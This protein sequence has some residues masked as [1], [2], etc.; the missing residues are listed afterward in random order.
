[1]TKKIF[2]DK[3]IEQWERDLFEN[4]PPPI[5]EI[6][7]PDFS[8]PKTFRASAATTGIVIST[9]NRDGNTTNLFLNPV[10]AK[11]LIHTIAMQGQ[12]AGWLNEKL[13]IISPD[14]LLNS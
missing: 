1:M 3:D 10:I 9:I 4:T 12:E 14:L 13:E 6:T 7:L 2:T 5:E 8:Q 11:Y